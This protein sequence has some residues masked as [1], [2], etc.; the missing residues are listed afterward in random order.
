VLEDGARILFVPFCTD[1]RQ[2]YM[3]VRYS[4]QQRASENQ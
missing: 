2:G 4:A 1:N 3:R